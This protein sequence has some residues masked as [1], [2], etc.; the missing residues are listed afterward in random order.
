LSRLPQ[1]EDFS[2]VR[3]HLGHSFVSPV[4]CT[5]IS[6][7]MADFV[8]GDQADRRPSHDVKHSH[9]AT[10]AAI[11][12]A[13]K[14]RKGSL[15]A[16][17]DPEKGVIGGVGFEP[18]DSDSEEVI[19]A[20]ELQQRSGFLRTLRGGEEWLDRKMG[21]ETQGIDRIHEEDKRP[22]SIINVFFLWWSLT[23]HVGT[24]PI[25]FLGPEFGLSLGQSVAMI[26]VGTIL[27]ALCTAY[28]GT[29]GPK[30]SIQT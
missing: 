12:S 3:P 27:G 10:D 26:V 25:G 14:A 18:Q 21:I 19:R 20:R 9:D 7:A 24:L 5:F 30:V 4:N 2:L 22:P 16:Y 15:P 28:C 1:L 13:E 23:C 11:P 6:A 17:P 8:H 29:L